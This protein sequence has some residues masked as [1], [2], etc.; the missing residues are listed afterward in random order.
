MKVWCRIK[1]LTLSHSIFFQLQSHLQSYKYIE[2][3]NCRLHKEAI[4][5]HIKRI[6]P[7]KKVK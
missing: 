4:K 5:N 3:L 6:I 7:N 2:K 1:F